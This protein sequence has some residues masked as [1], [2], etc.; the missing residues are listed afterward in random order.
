MLVANDWMSPCSWQYSSRKFAISAIICYTWQVI[1]AK[2]I[3]QVTC[4]P[5]SCPRVVSFSLNMALK[6]LFLLIMDHKQDVLQTSKEWHFWSLVL[7]V[8]SNSTRIIDLWVVWHEA[9]QCSIITTSWQ[10]HQSTDQYFYGTFCRMITMMAA[11]W[12]LNSSSHLLAEVWV[13][14]LLRMLMPCCDRTLHATCHSHLWMFPWGTTKK[15][16]P[17]QLVAPHQIVITL[18]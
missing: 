1:L 9:F 10:L 3:P 6:P 11:Q 12:S 5:T 17:A 2:H 8:H 14:E 15:H 7:T 18:W 13:P 16:Q 4:Q